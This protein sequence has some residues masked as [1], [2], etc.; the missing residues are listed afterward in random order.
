[1]HFPR[2]GTASRRFVGVAL[3]ALLLGQWTVLAHS[4]AH[5]PTTEASAVSAEPDH[6][7]D[8]SWDHATGTS[9]CQLVDH[10]LAGL[11]SAGEPAPAPCLPPAALRVAALCASPAP[12]PIARAYEARGPPRPEFSKP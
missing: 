6:V 11:A 12:G 9:T 3:L 4:I 7:G 1:M 8:H 5:A 2:H 10:L